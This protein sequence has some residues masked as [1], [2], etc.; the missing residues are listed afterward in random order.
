MQ[1]VIYLDYN[2]TTPVEPQVLDIMLPYFNVHYG[3]PSSGLH[4]QSWATAGAVKNARLQVA[5]LLN[6]DPSEVIFTSGATESINCALKGTLHKNPNY[7]L[8]TSNIEHAATL[9]VAFFLQ[10]NGFKVKFIEVQSNGLVAIEDLRNTLKNTDGPALVSLILAHNEIGSLY[11]LTPILELKKDY[12]F[13]LHLDATQALLT[14]KLDS[15]KQSFDMLSLS[16][17]KIYGPKGSGALYLRK[18]TVGHQLEA[19]I[20]GGG[21]EMNLRSG[22]LNV[23]GIV[24]L[25]AACKLVSERYDVDKSHFESLYNSIKELLVKA[26]LN[27]QL[28]GDQH[29]RI[30]Q[31]ISITLPES[32]EQTHLMSHL[33][34]F[35]LSQGSACSSQKSSVNNTLQAL[36]LSEKEM[37]RTLRI[38]LGRNTTLEDLEIFVNRLAN[39]V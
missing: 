5:S 20:H 30:F 29:S 28:N 35:C 22:T 15:Q 19:L 33:H 10:T 7:T 17:H 6:A 34:G 8:I 25:G 16:A 13:L 4:P 11:D 12:D 27:C 23:P 32:F 38:G 39:K 24:G 1:R 37:K 14:G 36:G 2:A 31:N 26:N 3:N 21:Q 9:N 18:S